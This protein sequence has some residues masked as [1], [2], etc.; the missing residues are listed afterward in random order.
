MGLDMYLEAKRTYYNTDWVK[1]KERKTAIQIREAIPEIKNID[2]GNLNYTGVKIEVGYWRKANAIHQWFVENCQ[3]GEDNCEEHYVKRENLKSLLKTC[4]E[5]IKESKLKDGK[6][7]NGYTIKD[8]TQV[9][10]LEDGKCV[11][12]PEIAEKLLPTTRGCFFGSTDYDEYYINDIKR[13]IKIIEECL[14]LPDKWSIYYR[15]S[16]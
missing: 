16:W 14:K 2:T 13:T 7:T 10:I 12:N 9:P 11:E 6:I 8:G 4:K 3:D 15:S 1:E 5:I